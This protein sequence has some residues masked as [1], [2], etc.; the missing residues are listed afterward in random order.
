MVSASRLC[1]AH[2][3][4]AKSNDPSSPDYVPTVFPTKHV[5]AKSQQDCDRAE[6]R[7]GREQ[8]QD[9]G[10]SQPS[11]SAQSQ[12]GENTDSDP[13]DNLE[14]DADLEQ[15][16]AEEE[17][18]YDRELW[19][20]AMAP[21]QLH[22]G[23]QT[24]KCDENWSFSW[25]CETISATEKACYAS[26]PKN[27]TQTRSVQMQTRKII[28][29]EARE[30][31]H[32]MSDAALPFLSFNNSQFIAFTGTSLTIFEFLS[33]H[34]GNRVTDSRSLSRELK[35]VLVLIKM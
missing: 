8:K 6:R 24:L 1:S 7:K 22:Y 35:L 14:A 23:V 16:P 34:V 32:S 29:T 30:P 10:P 4:S 26:L 20:Q 13:A 18:H 15:I 27:E 25:V 19:N 11:V 9:E 3:I 2:F 28:V 33:S 31:E 12:E 17:E 5:K 21:I